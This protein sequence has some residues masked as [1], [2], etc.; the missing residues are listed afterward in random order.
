MK[1]PGILLTVL[2]SAR[3]NQQMPGVLMNQRMPGI[4]MNQ[5]TLS[6]LMNQKIRPLSAEQTLA[7]F[8]DYSVLLLLLPHYSGFTANTNLQASAAL[9]LNS[10]WAL[11]FRLHVSSPPT[12]VCL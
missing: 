2:M 9:I 3:S 10:S 4:L 12:P 6:V 8:F 7:G 1:T 11:A 5:Q